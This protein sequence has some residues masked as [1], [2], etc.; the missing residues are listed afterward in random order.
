VAAAAAEPVVAPPLLAVRDLHVHLGQSHVLQGVTFDVPDGGVTAL[1]GRNGVGKTS[2]LR[3]I[4][5]LSERQ[6]SLLLGDEELASLPTHRIVRHRIGYVPEDRDVFTGL[7]VAEN[8]RLAERDAEPR[9]DLVYELFPELEQRGA[10]RAGTLSG[11]QQQMVAIA[12]A[13]LNDNRLLLVDEPTKGLAPALVAEVAR[14]LERLSELTTV[15]L[16]E[17]NLG[18]VRR[19]ARDVVVLDQGRVVHAGG[20]Q[21]LL[22]QPELVRRLL[23][24]SAGGHG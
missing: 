4:L 16:V 18:V 3:A 22:A 12:R 6:G 23:S 19:I 2:T 5:G 10:Q 21:E 13:L 14:V 20:A 17:Q 11:G 15:L 7:T 9:Y 1:L 8:L 24:V